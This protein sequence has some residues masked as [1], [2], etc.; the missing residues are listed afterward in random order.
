MTFE[1]EYV[2]YYSDEYPATSGKG[3]FFGGQV[4]IAPAYDFTGNIRAEASGLNQLKRFSSVAEFLGNA[5]RVILLF[6]GSIALIMYIYAGLLWMTA[7]G[8]TEQIGKAKQILVY[9]TLGVVAMLS[10]Y[11]LVEFVFG[12]LLLLNT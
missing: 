12:D 8:N 4:P 10:S 11:L 1:T 9:A 6:I 2:N 7:S 3:C 5:I